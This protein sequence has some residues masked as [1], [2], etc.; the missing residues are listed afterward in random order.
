MSIKEQLVWILAEG[1]KPAKE[2]NKPQLAAKIS[3]LAADL[4]EDNVEIPDDIMAIFP[5][6]ARAAVLIGFLLVVS[7]TLQEK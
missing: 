5:A 3:Q 2:I 1:E 6:D 4:G 7:Q